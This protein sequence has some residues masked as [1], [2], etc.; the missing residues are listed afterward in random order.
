MLSSGEGYRAEEVHSYMLAKVSGKQRP[1]IEGEF[2]V[3]VSRILREA[4]STTALIRDV[5]RRHNITE[6]TFSR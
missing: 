2:A 4:G 1:E 3:P 6:Q 5:C